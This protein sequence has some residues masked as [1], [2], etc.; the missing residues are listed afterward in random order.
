MS[1]INLPLG[2]NLHSLR[3]I[4]VNNKYNF[5][6]VKN[7]YHTQPNSNNDVFIY[8]YAYLTRINHE[9]ANYK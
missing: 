9:Q 8:D 3:G 6:A 2:T 5:T 7:K 1:M 4:S